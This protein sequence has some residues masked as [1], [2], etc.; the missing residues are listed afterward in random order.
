MTALG[1]FLPF[2]GERLN[3]PCDQKRTL[4]ALTTGI[5]EL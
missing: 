3:G 2:T 4:S 1:T 5:V